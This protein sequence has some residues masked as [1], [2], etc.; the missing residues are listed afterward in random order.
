MTLRERTELVRN[1]NRR[2]ERR[3]KPAIDE[4]TSEGAEARET[5]SVSTGLLR[6]LLPPKP[7]SSPSRGAAD[8]AEP[9]VRQA[10]RAR[11]VGK[12]VAVRGCFAA[13]LSIAAAA[14]LLVSTGC[15]ARS[16]EQVNYA[17]D[18]VLSTYNT[19]TVSG[20]ASAGPQA[21]ARALTGFTYHGPDGQALSDRDFGS[22]TMVGGEPLVLDYQISDDAV[23]S[24]GK[25]VT[26]TT[27]CSPGQPSPGGS[28]VLTPPAKPAT[29][30]SPV[31]IASPARRRPG[32]VSAGSRCFRSRPT[33]HRY[34]A[35]A[36]TRHRRPTRIDVTTA[37][38]N[39]NPEEAARIADSWNTI[40]ELKPDLDLKR[41]PSSARTK[42]I[43]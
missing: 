9:S 37:L 22:V 15:S 11:S 3:R 31:S 18:G 4:S 38:L 32:D 43:R 20:A 10:R 14:V 28:P 30:T 6:R 16:A 7:S 36:V 1:H 27:W 29:S 35:D 25:P 21:F 24:D 26:Q 40:W 8:T 5:V 33:V 23:Y 2:V 12:A 39:R 42:S 19:N 34:V 41:F 17:V 13:G